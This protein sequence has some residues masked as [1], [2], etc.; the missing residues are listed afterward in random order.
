MK[1]FVFTLQALLNTK[2]SLEKQAKADLADSQARLRLLFRE[3]ED[4]LLRVQ[5]RRNEWNDDMRAGGMHSADMATYFVGFRAL[6]E[7]AEAV[8]KKI[9]AAERERDRLQKKVVELMGER[10][11][12]EKLREKQREEYNELVRQEENKMMDDFLS[13][14]IS[15]GGASNG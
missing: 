4:I 5:L 15:T 2:I 8:R 3:K 10:K 9:A 11:V 14:Q 13:N 7:L 6:Q 12:L 1:R